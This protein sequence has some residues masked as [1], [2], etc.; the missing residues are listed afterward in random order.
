MHMWRVGS[1]AGAS[2]VEHALC[3]APCN[4]LCLVSVLNGDTIEVLHNTYP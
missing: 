4:W 1:Q 3:A 2:Y